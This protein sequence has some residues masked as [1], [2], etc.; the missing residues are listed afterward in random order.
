MGKKSD[1]AISSKK[2]LNGIQ[3]DEL[4]ISAEKI[5][6]DFTLF[7]GDEE[8]VISR[9]V[10]GLLNEDE[11][12]A[13]L[14]SISDMSVDEY[15]ATTVQPAED[16][17]RP[18]A[19]EVL[20]SFNAR[21]IRDQS[22]GAFYSAE[23]EVD[24]GDCFRRIGVIAQDRTSNNG[25][26]MPEHHHM[27]CD[28]A[29]MFAEMAL[30][31]VCL[32]DTPGADAGEVAN[33]NNQAHSISR[34]IAVL[35]NVNVPTVGVIIGI[36]Y[37]G[38]AIPMANSNILLSVRDGIFNT[39]Q[40]KGL[41]SIA[42]KYNLSWQ[43]CAKAVGVSP[44]ELYRQGCID[45]VIDFAPSDRGDKQQNLL[46]AV[47][48]SITSIEQS[49]GKF[50]ESNPNLLKHYEISVK[51][52]LNP[53]EKL[54]SI[55]NATNMMAPA[56]ATSHANLFGITY[57]Y[58]RYLTARKRLKSMTKG[59]Y[60]RLAGEE[61]PAGD[62]A[63]RID[64]EKE[65]VF[66]EWLQNPDRVV[67]E[68]Q[69]LKPWKNFV[70]K[71][72]ELA[73]ERGTI[74]KFVFG[75]PQENFDKA[76][77]ELCF[78]ISFFLY[79]RWKVGAQNNFS[80]L[81]Q[82]LQDEKTTPSRTD[83]PDLKQITL[84][85]VILNEEIRHD[86]LVAFQNIL[87]FDF[88][89]D[90]VTNNLAS[91]AEE[92]NSTKSL[93]KEAVTN[94]QV[95]AL[96]AALETFNRLGLEKKDEQAHSAEGLKTQFEDWLQFF[97]SHSARGEL[98]ASVEEWKTIG[99]PQTSD[100]LFVIITFFFEKLLPEYYKSEQSDAKYRGIINPARIGRRKDFWNRLTIAYHDLLIQDLLR[101]E[102]KKANKGTG[103]FL[104]RFV[105]GFVETNADL[106]SANPVNFPGF[107]IS[108][109]QAMEKGVTP[110]GVVTGIGDFKIGKDKQHVGLVVSNVA[111]QAGAF[112]M[113]AAAKFCSLLVTCAEQQL[114]VVCFISSG[115][116]QTKEGAA[117]LFSMAVVND[118]I[119]RFV[120]DNDL[121]IIAFGF[122]DCTG[123]AQA[124][125][126]TH[127]L[128][129]TYYF[130][131][132]NMPFAGQMVVPSYLPATSTLANYL[133]LVPGAM[134]GLVKHPFAETLDDE[135]RSID[136]SIPIPVSTVESVVARAL[137]GYVSQD[138]KREVALEKVD[139][140]A[141][142]Q[143]IKRT[144]IHARGCTAVKL[145]RIA[146]RRGIEVILV[147]SDPDMDSVP[148]A[149]LGEN[150]RVVCIGGNTSD[151]SYLNANSVIRVAEYEGVDSLHPGIGFLAE[152]SQFANLC[153][154]H[155][156]NFIG[157]SVYSMETMGNKS[158]AINTA[159]KLNVPVVP[160]SHGILS[161][162]D[163]AA[164]VA[165]DIGYP[166]LIKAVHG[167]GGKGIQVVESPDDIHAFFHKVSAEA[168]SAFGNGDIYLEKFITKLRHIEVQIL[169]DSHGNTRI[170]G[171]RDCSVQRNNQ[172][173][174]EESGSTM[175]PENLKK[176][177][178]NFAG[179][180][181][182]EVD[183]VGAGTV[184]FIYDLDANSV[185]FMEMN[186][187]LQVEHPVTEWVTGV[188][189]VGKQFA[190]ASG[191]AIDDIEVEEKG[192]A[193]E[194][195][196]TAEKAAQDSDGVVQLLPDPGYVSE[197]IFPEQE[198]IELISMVD[199]DK[200][201]SPFYDSLIA[202]VVCYGTD[203]DDT[204]AKMY[205]YLSTV[206][207]KGISTNI[208]LL[209]RILKDEIFVGGIYDT[210]YLPKF[211]DAVDKEALITEIEESATGV[212]VDFNIDDFRIE[213][214][215]ELKVVS[216]SM[217][218]YYSKASPAEPEFV[219]VGDV[220]SVNDPLCLMEAM[221]IYSS[222][223]LKSFNK[224]GAEL[225][226]SDTKYRVERINN[227]N[228]QQVSSGDLLFV[229]SPVES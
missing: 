21:I 139:A 155:G 217:G 196:V 122:G 185:Y 68:D 130:S 44:V 208:P 100:V 141:L 202:Q 201:V 49:V 140:R 13:S 71:R 95:D 118:R 52:F 32:M 39:I 6:K 34:L 53:S 46:R 161:T 221:K 207:I 50:V 181:A 169:R 225:F 159:L 93:S 54:A 188:D 17:A 174:L 210:T 134:Q 189:I 125:F 220:V 136:Q 89:Y 25:A 129:Q 66:G 146:Q 110:C 91:I 214:T 121:P 158:N 115:G 81:I 3:V 149:M 92:A 35:A 114:P 48:S 197:C 63:G 184:E 28:A 40:P 209:K 137:E 112:D 101:K 216:N 156:V 24:F 4:F 192:Y 123:G 143:P 168:K 194:V 58:M 148:V 151:E 19:R 23:M 205:D 70:S 186:T 67:Y 157:P 11:V 180:I 33:A 90:H 173:V 164:K 76:K 176:D 147:A 85:D 47:V 120:R 183:Y 111:F 108:I 182:Q 41:A 98:L 74:A 126:V 117:A 175:L 219:E 203:R 73:S 228:G 38:G 200:I 88:V 195:R 199:A 43:E 170:L 26:W 128:V 42:R 75:E 179:A 132:T 113:A 84:L 96:Q 223:N 162:A 37:S 83:I 160:G 94:L 119:T 31:I 99:H 226:S 135:L 145:I 29:H 27:A 124:S 9:H 142:M 22:Q 109:E 80:S 56:S 97:I 61:V 178:Q 171:I 177:V 86:C 30:P 15:I 153:I 166:V 12:D 212:A 215:D 154:N 198:N 36:G 222:I 5:A 82:Y 172:K 16:P 213:G 167:G 218:I 79:N 116:M 190:I 59:N 204:I 152:N 229:V 18:A 206:S 227:A 106:I 193:I 104:D 69:L 62:L 163:R 20:K 8:F 78:T 133:Y 51:R 45:G 55:Q 65:Y 7:S 127:P 64:L 77:A 2:E 14:S 1:M 144:L 102:K 87:I 105:E 191:E 10:E 165:N 57:R 60:G 224:V 187:R 72:D 150:D 138:A 211:L 107:R 103:R 131:G